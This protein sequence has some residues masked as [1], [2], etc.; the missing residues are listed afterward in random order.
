MDKENYVSLKVFLLT[1][2]WLRWR[3]SCSIAAITTQFFCYRWMIVKVWFSH[4]KLLFLSSFQVYISLTKYGVFDRFQRDAIM[5]PNFLTDTAN[6][7]PE[8]VKFCFVSFLPPLPVISIPRYC[9]V[10]RNNVCTMD[11]P[12]V[13]H[14]SWSQTQLYNATVY[15]KYMLRTW[16]NDNVHGNHCTLLSCCSST[17]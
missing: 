15:C 11:E 10:T 14:R 5:F 6:S 3:V 16:H 9:T 7:F 1:C 2:E 13:T 12:T 8:Q 17:M 4:L